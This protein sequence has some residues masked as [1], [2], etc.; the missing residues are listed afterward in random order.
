[1]GRSADKTIASEQ[2]RRPG[3]VASGPDALGVVFEAFGETEHEAR[4][5][6]IAEAE[7]R[8]AGSRR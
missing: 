6:W 2:A 1:M 4:E 7:R 5:H 3:F 8:A